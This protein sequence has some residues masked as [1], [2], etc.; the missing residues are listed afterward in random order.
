MQ[1]ITVL[2]KTGLKYVMIVVACGQYW[3]R[4]FLLAVGSSKCLMV[5]IILTYFQ[6]ILSHVCCF[7]IVIC[8]FYNQKK[9]TKWW[10]S[11]LVKC[12]GEKFAHFFFF[13][14]FF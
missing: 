10:I 14:F 9:I 6:L 12:Q 7:S 11:L 4:S 1:I 2:T 13:F 5:N 8:I 3:G